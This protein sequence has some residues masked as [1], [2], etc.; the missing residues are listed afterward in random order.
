MQRVI[1][2]I[3]LASV[4]AALPGAAPAQHR[5]AEAGGAH[6]ELGADVTLQ[7]IDRGAGIGSGV[8][9]FA[10]VDVRIGF[11]SR[12]PLM[13]EG[14]AAVNWDSKA[15]AGGNSFFE[16]AP[17]VN[18]LYRLRRGSGPGGLSRAPYLTGGLLLDIVHDG[19]LGSQTQFVVNAGVGT[20]VPY[21]SAVFRPEAFL[22][23]GFASGFLP[24]A[25]MIGVRAG[26]SF[27]H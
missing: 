2:G 26:L 25:F 16:F 1:G 12:S 27:W 19:T 20:R 8:Q 18:A 17:G 23:Y 24:R 4:L 6:H 15:G 21:E 10:P 3:A 22:A 9:L 7:Y 11:L 13:F 14:R 5:A